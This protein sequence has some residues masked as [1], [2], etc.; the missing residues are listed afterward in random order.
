MNK[1][2][3]Y[4]IDWAFQDIFEAYAYVKSS[5]VFDALFAIIAGIILTTLIFKLTGIVKDM[6]ADG[7]GFNTRHFLSLGKNIWQS[8]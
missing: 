3:Q 1:A 4:N 5:I 2:P 8:C 6:I 7:K